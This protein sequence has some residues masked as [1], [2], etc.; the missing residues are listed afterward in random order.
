MRVDFHKI[1]ESICKY[2][3]NQNICGG[4]RIILCSIEG[5]VCKI[6][7]HVSLSNVSHLEGIHD[8]YCRRG[9]QT[10]A[11]GWLELGLMDAVG[12]GAGWCVELRTRRTQTHT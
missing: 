12:I 10:D 2:V 7:I 4:L 11:M 9:E 5:F 8:G 3:G 6:Y 1:E